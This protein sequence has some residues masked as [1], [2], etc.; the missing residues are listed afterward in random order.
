MSRQLKL[1][2]KVMQ[3]L[4]CFS[5]NNTS[6]D[7]LG[8]GELIL[9]QDVMLN[10]SANKPERASRALNKESSSVKDRNLCA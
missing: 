10:G 3:Y 7:V 6:I 9:V 2:L 1:Y 8:V 5:L 4:R